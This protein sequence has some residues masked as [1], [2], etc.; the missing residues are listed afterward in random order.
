MS[1]ETS[2]KRKERL[3]AMASKTREETQ[4]VGLA[5]YVSHSIE[6]DFYH[7]RGAFEYNR[8]EEY[9]HGERTR[10]HDD[11]MTPA[12]IR[13]LADLEL[14]CQGDSDRH[15]TGVYAWRAEYRGVYSIDLG[16]AELMAATLKKL[17]K[18]LNKL[19]EEWGQPSTYGQ[20]VLRVC[21][22]LGCTRMAFDSHYDGVFYLDLPSGASKIDGWV[23]E[24]SENHV[25]AAS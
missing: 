4:D 16:R 21:K 17:E 24:W 5:L 3:K 13:G 15:A 14:S 25:K 19:A 23:Y 9:R 1:S 20:F 18:G 6:G 10:V 7:I 11:Y 8:P 12:H 22:V 2:D